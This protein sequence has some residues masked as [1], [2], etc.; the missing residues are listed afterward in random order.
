MMPPALWNTAI[1]PFSRLS[2]G[3]SL[4]AK[5]KLVL[6][7]SI[8]PVFGTSDISLAALLAA[9][10]VLCSWIMGEA[11]RCM[12]GGAAPHHAGP[13]AGEGTTGGQMY[14]CHLTPN[15]SPK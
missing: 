8:V 14:A 15:F 3:F 6:S 2:R 11:G 7:S 4:I 10:G 13:L 9:F 1:F 5:E 12:A